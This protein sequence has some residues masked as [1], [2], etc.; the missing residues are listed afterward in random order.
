VVLA[1]VGVPQAAL[2]SHGKMLLELLLLK[3]L[4]VGL[5][6]QEGAQAQV[7][8]SSAGSQGIGLVTALTGVL[9]ALGVEVLEAM[10]VLMVGGGGGGGGGQSGTCFVCGEVGHWSRDCPQKQQT[11]GSS[12]GGIGA[13]YGGGSQGGI[14]VV[15]GELWW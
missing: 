5:V 6:L 11:R 9:Q 14:G 8:A 2:G 1:L 4:G 15:P 7:L 10:E 3:G 13:S 12:F